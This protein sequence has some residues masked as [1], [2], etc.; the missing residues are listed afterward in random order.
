MVVGRTS[1]GVRA[2]EV[3]VE[4]DVVKEIRLD[5][6]DDGVAEIPP[7][8]ESAIPDCWNCSIGSICSIEVLG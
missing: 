6:V 4:V 1:R 3:V 8:L 2:D 5:G 7:L